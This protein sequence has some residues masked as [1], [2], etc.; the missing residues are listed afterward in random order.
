MITINYQFADGHFEEIEVTEEF[1]LEYAEIE[2][3]SRRN[4]KKFDWRTRNKESSLD[5]MREDC[6]FEIQDLSIPI[7]EQAVNTDFIERFTELLTENQR[8]VFRKVYIE[9]KPLRVVSRELNL[10]LSNIQKY[11]TLIEK[12]YKK[13][14]LK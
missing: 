11:I 8:V 12:K 3:Q 2:K 10:R 5:R 9:N 13:N 14:F 4:D 1:A 6:G 7:D